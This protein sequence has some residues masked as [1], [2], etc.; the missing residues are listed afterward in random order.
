QRRQFQ[1]RL[2]DS[3]MVAGWLWDVFANIAA[4]AE[5]AD[6][7]QVVGRAMDTVV[8]YFAARLA[9]PRPQGYRQLF[10]PLTI[11]ALVLGGLGVREAVTSRSPY[12][13]FQDFGKAAW[14]EKDAEQRLG[15]TRAYGSTGHPI[16]FG[17]TM[18]LVTG[19]LLSIR[20]YVRPRW[21]WVCAM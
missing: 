10:I 15:F 17:M 1:W 18:F 11:C 21:L 9:L 3:V 14:Y 4:G 2:I 19:M 12:Q 6:V 5:Q 20:G 13:P 8:P 16:Y 7:I